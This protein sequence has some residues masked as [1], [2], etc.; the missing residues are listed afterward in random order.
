MTEKDSGDSPD[1]SQLSNSELTRQLPV[2]LELMKITNP[3]ILEKR[4]EMHMES[5]NFTPEEKEFVTIANEFI[6]EKYEGEMRE[7]SDT[8][9][10]LHPYRLALAGDKSSGYKIATK[11]LHDA[12]EDFDDVDLDTIR[13]LFTGVQNG[14]PGELIVKGVDAF[15]RR[16]EN[17][18]KE[19]YDDYLRR[20]KDTATRDSSLTYLIGDKL[21][22]MTQNC[23]DPMGL[24][25]TIKRTEGIEDRM[26]KMLHK[27]ES[28]ASILADINDRR[29]KKLGAAIELS[30]R[31]QSTQNKLAA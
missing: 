23:L 11:L 19:N 14:I 27:Y 7:N 15:S 26:N 9:A 13:S 8:P 1:I 2:E 25:G 10:I 18:V 21:A 17:D 5:A 28:N 6:K 24:P 30:R 20:L 3:A 29:R 16:K 12:V 31:A 4:L 22:D